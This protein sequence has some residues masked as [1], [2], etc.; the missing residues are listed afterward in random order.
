[1][2]RAPHP[3]AAKVFIN[4]YLSRKGQVALQTNLAKLDS[5]PDSLRVD[6]P[7]ETV[8]PGTR[9]MKGVSYLDTGKP[10]WID[11]RPIHRIVNQAVQ[12]KKQ[13]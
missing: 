3:N 10:E 13:K 11:M 6:I 12:M 1:M 8:P 5:G 2:N 7:K 4:W 9:R